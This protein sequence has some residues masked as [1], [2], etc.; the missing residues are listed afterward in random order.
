MFKNPLEP[1]VQILQDGKEEVGLLR[2][3]ILPCEQ[4]DAGWETAVA[5]LKTVLNIAF[6]TTV[7]AGA[8]LRMKDFVLLVCSALGASLLSQKKIRIANTSSPR[9][10]GRVARFRIGVHY[11]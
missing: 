2:R 5:V 4:A 6:D 10:G 9:V 11:K 3:S 8:M 7:T 1:F